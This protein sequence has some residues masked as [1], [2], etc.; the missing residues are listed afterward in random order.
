MKTGINAGPGIALR[1]WSDGSSKSDEY[2]ERPIKTPS[3]TPTSTATHQPAN[4]RRRLGRISRNTPSLRNRCLGGPD[5]QSSADRANMSK[6][7]GKKI[8]PARIVNTCQKIIKQKHKLYRTA[9]ERACA[10]GGTIMERI[11][12]THSSLE[13]AQISPD[14]CM[15]VDKSENPID[16]QPHDSGDCGACENRVHVATATGNKENVRTYPALG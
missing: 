16:E 3:E 15:S 2:R 10:S 13:D 12:R 4:S 1:N 9:T 14:K 7:V 11:L 8:D 5:S 6:G